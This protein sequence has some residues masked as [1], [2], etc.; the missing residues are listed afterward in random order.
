MKTIPLGFSRRLFAP[1]ALLLLVAGLLGCGRP[2]CAQGDATYRRTLLRLLTLSRQQTQTL[3]S[4]LRTNPSRSAYTPRRSYTDPL[5]ARRR[6]ATAARR[7]ITAYDPLGGSLYP[8]GQSGSSG[9]PLADNRRVLNSRLALPSRNR[10]DVREIRTVS[11][12]RTAARGTVL[13]RYSAITPYETQRGILATDPFRART[14]SRSG[15]NLSTAQY[16]QLLRELAALRRG[17]VELN[18]RVDANSS[19][20]D[21]ILGVKRY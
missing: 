7:P 11:N 1:L 3:N 12:R 4:A 15:G 2:V 19:A 8:T 21:N 20:L 6:P 5:P 18:R 16:N 13:P 9:D 10:M 14:T 17:Q